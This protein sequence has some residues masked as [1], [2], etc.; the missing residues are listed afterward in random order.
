MH[1]RLSLLYLLAVLVFTPL[2][3]VA[4]SSFYARDNLVLDLSRGLEW[5]RCSVGQR[6]SLETKSCTGK[7]VQLNHAEIEQVIVQA[8]DQLG[9]EWRLPNRDELESLVCKECGPPMID[10]EL[11]PQTEPMP[12]WTSEK[13][14]W[15]PKNYWSVNF[16]TGFTYGRFFPNQPQMLRLV[17][18]RRAGTS[19]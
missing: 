3:L 8:N 4:Q 2:P 6:W 18:N 16:M 10:P 1:A 19:N 11:F 9:P 13:N 14:F 7:A 15:S 17:R 12:Y 5:M